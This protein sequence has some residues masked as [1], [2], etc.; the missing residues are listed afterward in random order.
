MSRSIT[1]AVQGCCHGE[2]DTIYDTILQRQRQMG[3]RVD[4]L[5]ICG[6]FESVRSPADLDS[7]AVPMKYR[8]MNSFHEY[9]AGTKVRVFQGK[10]G[11]RMGTNAY[12]LFPHL[13]AAPTPTPASSPL[14]SRPIPSRPVP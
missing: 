10:N 2:L 14:P 13:S 1:V 4:L 11:W 3:V 8:H 12:T 7:M 6:D 9:A 5:V